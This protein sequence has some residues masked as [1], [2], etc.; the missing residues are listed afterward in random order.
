MCFLCGLELLRLSCGFDSRREHSRKLQAMQKRDNM[1]RT[2]LF[3]N[4][5]CCPLFYRA[6]ARDLG[7]YASEV[8]HGLQRSAEV[9]FDCVA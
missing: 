1:G 4:E 5:P 3:A 8:G 2:N 7:S 9:L 6:P